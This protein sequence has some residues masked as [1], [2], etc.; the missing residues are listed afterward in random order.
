[1][2]AVLWDLDGT[3]TDS[4][5]FVVDTANRVIEAHGGVALDH[6][7]VGG[8]T[9]LP[10]EAIFR[11]AWPDLTPDDASRY[12]DEYRAIYDREIVPATRLFRGARAALHAFHQAGLVQATVTG[13]RAPD[14][15]RILRGLRI[16]NEID[17]YLGGDSVRHAKPAPDLALAAMER[18]G[19]R[20][21]ESVVVGDAPADIGMAVAAGARAIQV[22][23]GWSTERLDGADHLV[24]TWPEL[25]R[26]VF[27]L[28]GRADPILRGRGPVRP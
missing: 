17:A 16:T 18:I 27:R 22:T 14:C 23:W 4:V 20:P 8:M 15:E 12:R 11:M 13:K 6:E 28:A 2:R 24:R 9:G 1:V 7:T 26:V 21:E 5:R 10:L 3:L 19:A 25:R